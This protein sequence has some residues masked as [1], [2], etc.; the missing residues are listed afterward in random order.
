MCLNLFLVYVATGTIVRSVQRMFQKLP[1][2][3]HPLIDL[4]IP[5]LGPI[6]NFLSFLPAAFIPIENLHQLTVKAVHAKGPI[7]RMPAIGGMGVAIS[8]IGRDGVRLATT[9]RD[10]NDEQVLDIQEIPCMAKIWGANNLGSIPFS[11]ARKK[12]KKVICSSNKVGI[13]FLVT[14]HFPLPRRSSTTPSTTSPSTPSSP[15]CR[16][17]LRTG[18]PA[19]SSRP[20]LPAPLSAARTRFRWAFRARGGPVDKCSDRTL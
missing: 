4:P 3:A 1:P 8:V 18:W 6:F 12:L 5:I 14:L 2:A 19:T 16:R 10:E 13:N 7:V 9:L 17:R 20:S 11:D 15:A